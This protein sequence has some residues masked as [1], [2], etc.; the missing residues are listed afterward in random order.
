MCG[1]CGLVE[2]ESRGTF[3]QTVERMCQA[4]V[5]RGPDDQGMVVGEGFALGMRR[6]SIID[7]AGGLQ[8]IHNEDRSAW[9]VFNGEVYNYREL[10]D[11]LRSSGHR[12]GCCQPTCFRG[13]HESTSKWRSVETVATNSS[14]A[15]RRS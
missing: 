4:M 5:H 10:R 9:L 3:T 8:P 12:F 2:S 13:S 11:Q 15:I 6:L 1:I 7:I 14:P